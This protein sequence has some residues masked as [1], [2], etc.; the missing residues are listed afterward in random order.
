MKRTWAVLIILVVVVAVV[1]ELLVVPSPYQLSIEAPGALTLS[2]SL[3]S[4]LVM[5]NQTMRV[6]VT[7]RNG[8]PL[9][10]ELPFPGD[11]RAKNLSMRPCSSAPF[12]I[13]VYFGRYTMG[14]VSSASSI[15]IYAPGAYF[16]PNMRGTPNSFRFEPFQIV[17]D[18]VDLKGYWT[19]GLTTHP[20]GGVSEGVLRP[21]LPG[22]Y[23]VAA[24]DEWGHLQ[25]AYFEVRGIGLQDF[26]LCSSNCVYPSPYLSGLIYFD[27]GAPVKSLQLFVNGTDQGV[28]LWS[29][30]YL[31]RFAE[32]YKGG[33]QNP[34]VVKGDAYMLRFVATFQDNSTAMATTTVVAG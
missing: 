7:D 12:G 17:A 1:V 8:L 2:T 3:N 11:W 28:S 13:A 20:G 18:Y 10:N 32:Q 5:Q 30:N 29:G 21:F 16:C 19:Q 25:M 23:T 4:T 24:G 34:A 9:V 15:E 33:F 22:I 26:S 14:N 27:A 31:T 6:T